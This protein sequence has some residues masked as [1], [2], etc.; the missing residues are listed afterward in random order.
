M[1]FVEADRRRWLN[2]P[3]DAGN[4]NALSGAGKNGLPALVEDMKDFAFEGGSWPGGSVGPGGRA[5][6]LDSLLRDADEDLIPDTPEVTYVGEPGFPANALR[7][8]ASPFADPQ[9]AHTFAGMKWR[10]AEVSPDMHASAHDD[11]LTLISDG[12][13]WRYFKG[14][15]EPSDDA[16]DWR[17]SDFTDSD[18]LTGPTPIGYG[19]AFVATNL[20]DMRGNYTTVYLRKQFDVAN[21]EGFDSLL[22]E[23]L[24]DDGLLV[25]ING[26]LVVQDNVAS[27]DLPHDAT[28]ESAIENSDFVPYSFSAPATYLVEGTNTIA[29]QLLNASLSG[30]SD[31]FFDLRLTGHLPSDEPSQDEESVEAGPR[32]YEFETLWESPELTTFEPQVSIPGSVVEAGRTY[33]VRCRMKDNTSRCSHWSA[34][35]QF[36]AG[37]PISVGTRSGLRITELMYNPPASILQPDIDDEDFE[38]I[39]LKNTSDEMLDLSDV[40]FVDGVEFDF[41]DGDITTLAPGEFVLVVR[42][43]EAFTSRYGAGL[44]HRIAGQY[45][46]K[47]ANEGENVRL[48]DLWNGAIAEFTYDDEAGWPAL[49]DGEGHSL[50]PLES[51][52]PGEPHGSLRDPANWRASTERGGSPGLDDPQ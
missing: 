42:N 49:A 44:L 11:S 28:A 36:Q 35:M 34:P 31:C 46:G 24:Y 25:W 26:R 14:L 17:A 23:T 4:Y 5:A 43:R 1:E 13:S 20:S 22:L 7:F 16:E 21:A 29:V 32:K 2:A 45:E 27:A 40:S 33:R 30:S 39:E 50:V 47:L 6:F 51:A 18:W 19:E 9:G 12:T 41:R 38:F 48:V 3:S 15:A 8:Q 10:I 37:E 52:L